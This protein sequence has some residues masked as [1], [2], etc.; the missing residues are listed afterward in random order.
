MN[1]RP[2]GTPELPVK[3]TL[4]IAEADSRLA[5]GLECLLAREFQ[6]LALAHDTNALLDL[7]RR[8]CPDVVLHGLPLPP[9]SGADGIDRVRHACPGVKVVAITG[10]D[11]PNMVADAFRAG[12]S[13]YIL[14]QSSLSELRTALVEAMAGRTYVTPLIADR[15]MR[16][17]AQATGDGAYS[18]YMTQRQREV[19]SLLVQGKSMKEAAVILRFKEPSVRA[20]RV[21][22]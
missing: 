7:V 6:I 9:M 20:A 16:V 1:I 8:H 10:R 13:G 21:G 15:A 18:S 17:L 5:A 12:A 14:T 4:V 22:P 3:A 19:V 11:D 2:Q